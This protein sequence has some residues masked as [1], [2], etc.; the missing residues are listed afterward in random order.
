MNLFIFD[1][2]GTITIEDTTDL[3][4]EIPEKDQIW[5]IEEEWKIGNLTSYQ[6]MKKQAK[7]LKGIST[8]RIFN[9]LKK[10]SRVDPGFLRLVNYLKARNYHIIVLSEGYDLSIKFHE[11]RK[12]VKDIHCSRLLVKRDKLIGELEVSN[13][14]K[15]S[16]N[17]NCVGCCIC[18]VDFVNKLRR[19]SSEPKFTKVFAVGD[20]RSDACL[21]QH[22]D[23][24]FSL[25]SDYESN[26]QVKNLDNVLAILKK[27]DNT[28]ATK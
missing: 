22:V 19:S 28:E 4:L 27:L 2:D 9:Q 26:Y 13:N 10:R 17:K 8:R 16:Y 12:F 18:K 11:V 15:W 21:F 25:N 24:S 1:F 5:Q 14:K 3:I 20:G 6:C 23:V 7:F